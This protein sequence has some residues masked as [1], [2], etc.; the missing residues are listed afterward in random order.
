MKNALLEIGTEHLPA[1]FLLPTLEEL[2]ENAAKILDEHNLKFVSLRTFGTYRRL[3]L[4]IK[5]LASKAED[6]QKEVKGPPAKL[7]KDA[8]G[9]FTPQ[10]QGFAEKNGIAPQNLIVVETEKGPFIYAKITQKGEKTEKILP[11]IFVEIIKSLNFPKNMVWEESGLRFARPIRNLIGL[12]GDKVVKFEIAGVKSGRSTYPLSSFGHKPIKIN[13]PLDYSKTLKNQPQPI[14][15]E[16]EE[17][18]TALEKSVL[19]CAK[20]LGYTAD[21]DPELFMETV[22]FSEHP[23]ALSGNFDIRFLTLPKELITT[24]LKK[25]IKMFPVLNEKGEIQP[26]FIAVRDGV[27]VNQDEVRTGFGNVMTARLTDAVF[28]FENDLKTGLARL[29]EKLASVNFIDGMGNMLDKTTRLEVAAFELAKKLQLT[30]DE[31]EDLQTAASYAYGDLTS[32]VVYEF[33]ELQ[34]YMGGV[35]AAKEGFKNAVATA[36]GEFYLPLSAAG[37]L[38][39]TLIGSLVSLAGKM[40]TLAANFAMGQ[41]P[42][43]SEDPFA[44]RRQAMGA[45][46]IILDKNLPITLQEIIDLS[47]ASLPKVENTQ[48]SKLYDFMWQRMANLLEQEG[49]LQ[50]EIAAVSQ[51]KNRT[52][53]QIMLITKALIAARNNEELRNLAE[54]AKRV[55]NILKKAGEIKHNIN[56]ELFEEE[57]ERNL[58]DAFSKINNALPPYLENITQESCLAALTELAKFR[59]PLD[60]FFEKVMVNADNIAVKNNRLAL[61]K[62][63]NSTLTRIVADLSK[64]QKRG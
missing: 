34:G 31:K 43:G 20:N 9:N 39:K 8:N 59:A 57:A 62:E 22:A 10:S 18:K 17:R 7:L 54:A 19:A 24:V 52:L 4:E 61:L 47:A 60:I 30:Q 37:Q 46:R 12:Y 45:V 53:S 42:S 50:D 14:L 44:L 55:G 36:L 48:I 3:L 23:I 15:A 27:S 38:P 56:P 16:I 29:K 63:I 11:S 26:H 5:E 33:P 6:I 40:D 2:R 28:F 1:R 35:Y 32:S 21:M 58:F 51:L 25:Q 49:A 13:D 64:L 41:V